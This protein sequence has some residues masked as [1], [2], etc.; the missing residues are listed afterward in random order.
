LAGARGVGLVAVRPAHDMTRENFVSSQ[1]EQDIE[2]NLY[3]TQPVG[4]VEIG[5]I[6]HDSVDLMRHLPDEYRADD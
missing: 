5:R 2:V 3:R 6:L 4:L 1:A